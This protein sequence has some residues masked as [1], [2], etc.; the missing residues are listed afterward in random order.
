MYRYVYTTR[1]RVFHYCVGNECT[2][3]PT[4]MIRFL[5]DRWRGTRLTS[6]SSNRHHHSKTYQKRFERFHNA[7]SHWPEGGRQGQERLHLHG[8]LATTS[9]GSFSPSAFAASMTSDMTTSGPR[10]TA[11]GPSLGRAPQSRQAL[12]QFT[13]A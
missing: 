3:T 5:S 2:F 11:G 12:P 8:N 4:A 9:S 1:A 10:G 13:T 6:I 7:S